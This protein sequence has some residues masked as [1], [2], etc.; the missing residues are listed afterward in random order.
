[1]SI[2][3]TLSAVALAVLAMPAQAQPVLNAMTAIR[4]GQWRIT[5]E[6]EASRAMCLANPE[7]LFQIRHGANACARL[8]I[9]DEKASATVHYSC[10]GAGWGRT[11]LRVATPDAVRI[12]TQGIAGNAPFEYQ[13]QARRIGDCPAR[14]ASR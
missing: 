12:A 10:P 8:V 11:T 4:P 6:G 14:S 3:R 5:P 1:M 2:A 9:A 13:A 7:T